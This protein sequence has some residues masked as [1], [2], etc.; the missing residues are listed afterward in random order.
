MN[1]HAIGNGVNDGETPAPLTQ[2]CILSGNDRGRGWLG[3]KS[4]NGAV[5]STVR[6]REIEVLGV[7][8]Q[9][10]LHRVARV[11]IHC[12]GKQ[13]RCDKLNVRSHLPLDTGDV[14][15][16][17]ESVSYL[18]GRAMVWFEAELKDFSCRR[19][20]EHEVPASDGVV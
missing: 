9:Q 11:L 3:A 15:L 12:V 7:D 5:R 4:T 1:P 18:R 6:D 13:L 2:R 17:S 19:M 14:E 10:N 16:V 20:T 8:D